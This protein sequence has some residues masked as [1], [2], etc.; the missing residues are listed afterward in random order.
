M[1]DVIG[2]EGVCRNRLCI[3]KVM[4]CKVREEV[5]NVLVC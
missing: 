4:V 1:R 3:I 2:C 5:E